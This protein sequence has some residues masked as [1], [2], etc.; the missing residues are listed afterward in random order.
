MTSIELPEGSWWDWDIVSCDAGQLR[1][2]AGHDLTYHHG[3]ELI[4]HGPA[5]V[6]CPIG[7]QDPVFRAPTPQ[8]LQAITSRVGELPSL[9]VA[10]EADAGGREL[11]T[12]LI[13]AESVEV[14]LGTVFRYWR[15]NLTPGEGLA[16][17]VQPPDR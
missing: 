3:L 12:C 4:F 9:L 5:I 8:E 16:P 17:W 7:F 6:N 11:T 14:K 10:F 2:G 13:A 15:E 1:L